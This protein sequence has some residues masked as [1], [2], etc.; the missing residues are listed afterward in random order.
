M[1]GTP[2][3]QRARLIS[4]LCHSATFG[5]L[6]VIAAQQSLQALTWGPVLYTTTISALQVW[7]WAQGVESATPLRRRLVVATAIGAERM[8]FVWSFAQLPLGSALGIHLLGGLLAPL[9]A[10][11]ALGTTSE[12]SQQASRGLTWL[13]VQLLCLSVAIGS[14]GRLNQRSFTIALVAVLLRIIIK[15]FGENDSQESQYTSL[16]T[17]KGEDSAQL[18]SETTRRETSLIALVTCLATLGL[19]I[20]TGCWIQASSTGTLLAI[21]YAFSATVKDE[22]S[23]ISAA[24]RESKPQDA[25]SDSEK[26]QGQVQ[27]Q[28]REDYAEAAMAA[29][30]VA[31]ATAAHRWAHTG[32]ANYQVVNASMLALAGVIVSILEYTLGTSRHS[33]VEPSLSGKPGDWCRRQSRSDS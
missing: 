14:A 4:L 1:A 31:A 23:R 29:G 6:A 17:R 11:L 15:M 18:R 10:N 3:G 5:C 19:S 33:K 21:G 24:P 8:C 30:L 25:L 22:W 13:P 26:T 9:I 7:R 32:V 27:E 20:W 16:R 28:F 2:A 12:D